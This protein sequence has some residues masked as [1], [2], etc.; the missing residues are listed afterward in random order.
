VINYDV[1][2]DKDSYVHRI[3][4]T[5]RAGHEGRAVSIVTRDDLMDLYAIEEH[6]GV[7]IEECE[8]PG[9]EYLSEHRQEIDEWIAAN[10]IKKTDSRKTAEKS[11]AGSRDKRDRNRPDRR[12]KPGTQPG[13]QRSA[14]EGTAGTD[15][16]SRQHKDTG[17]QK[18]EDNRKQRHNSG[19]QKPYSRTEKTLRQDTKPNSQDTRPLHQDAKPLRRSAENR[20][21]R[22]MPEADHSQKSDGNIRKPGGEPRKSEEKPGFFRRILGRILGR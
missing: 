12:K 15:D 9:D 2:L 7:L 6:I 3:G 17:K 21:T 18:P 5:G 22:G 16:A 11:E 10:T 1:P 20:P 14:P 8:L 4:R 19:K 13:T